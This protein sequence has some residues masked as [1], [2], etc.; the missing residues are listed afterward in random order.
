MIR[1]R[2][3]TSYVW[4]SVSGNKMVILLNCIRN[5]FRKFELAGNSTQGENPAPENPQ[6]SGMRELK[7]MK[8]M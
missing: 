1:R 6:E 4:N 2:T 5:F 7:S 3:I 8:L